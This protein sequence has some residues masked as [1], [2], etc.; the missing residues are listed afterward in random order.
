[1]TARLSVSWPYHFLRFRVAQVTCRQRCQR[2]SSSPRAALLGAAAGDRDLISRTRNIGIIAHIDAGKTTTTERMLYY[3]GFTRRLGNVDD[4]STVTDFLPAERA[5]GITIQSAAVTLYWPPPPD[6]SHF[7]THDPPPG[8]YVINLI[9]TPGHADVTFEVLRSQRFLDGAVCVLDGVAGVE[10]QTEK[11]WHQA[12]N[13]HIPKLIYVNKLDREGAGFGRTVREI[14]AKLHVWPAVCQLPWYDARGERLQGIVDVVRMKALLWPHDGDGKSCEELDMNELANA[15]SRL[16][17]EASKARVALIE[18]LTEH[19]ELIVERFLEL[20]DYLAIPPAEIW[21]CLRRCNLSA[22]AAIVPVFAG[23]SLRNIGVQP[24]LDAVTGLLPSPEESQSPEIKA[25]EVQ[26]DLY[27]L[28]DGRLSLDTLPGTAR[29]KAERKRQL[30][31]QNLESCALAFKVVNDL[32]RGVLVY[33]RV[34]HG[35]LNRN[36]LVFNTNL[37]TVERVPRLLRMF[38]S[39]AF[40]VSHI[41]AGQIGV[42]TGLKHARTGDTLITSAG[43]N[44]KRGPSPPLNKLQLRPI[45]VPPPVFFTGIEPV[46]RSEEQNVEKALSMLL[47][48]DPSLHLS[49]DEDTGQKLLSGMGELHLEIARDHLLNDLKA[50]ASIGKIEIGYRECILTRAGPCSAIIERDIA[51][52]YSKAGCSVTVLPVGHEGTTGAKEADDTMKS[53]D[54]IIQISIQRPSDRLDAEDADVLPAHLSPPAVYRTLRT[55]ALAALARG[56]QHGYLIHGTHVQISIELQEHIFRETNLAVLT[57]AARQ[58]TK[59]ALS[60]SS[61]AKATALVEPVMRVTV[62]IDAASLGP[63]THDIQSARSGQIESLDDADGSA[64]SIVNEGARPIDMRRVYSPLDPHQ[65][66]NQLSVEGSS[67]GNQ[68]QYRTIQA[69]VPLR[70]M[71]GYLKHLRSLTAGRGSFVMSVDRFEKVN[72]KREKSLLNELRGI[73]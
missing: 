7:E 55:G 67:A 26:G 39:D 37:Q 30:S 1:M 18:L 60:A 54:N 65:G 13:Y 8:S 44:P 10:A 17:Q 71:V 14:A 48:E 72:P 29:P 57:A 61:R 58:A 59:D 3:G 2:L 35:N 53:D 25:G 24:L 56:P 36:A 50:K 49:T 47:R 23:S 42:I 62:S 66:L 51:G 68:S 21:A 43:I 4:G 31:T 27:D 20:N 52:V 28:V 46:S 70:E 5:R 6:Q 33:V 11:V 73:T 40:E 16:A 38:A 45:D 34:Y 15:E 63:V 12:Q 9:D 64:N 69:K 32:K 22:N 19:D 41:P